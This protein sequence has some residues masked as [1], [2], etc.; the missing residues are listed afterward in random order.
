[1]SS[2]NIPPQVLEKAIKTGNPQYLG[3]KRYVQTRQKGRNVKI[4]VYRKEGAKKVV[5]GEWQEFM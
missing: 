5:E 3:D 1:M 2:L 4:T